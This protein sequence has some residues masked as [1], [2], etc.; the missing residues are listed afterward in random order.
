MS[1]R[2]LVS[3]I[4]V[5][6]NGEKVLK[7]CLGSLKKITYP[8]YEIILV[9]NGSTDGSLTVVESYK[10]DLPI[11]LLTNSKNLGFAPANNQG[12]KKAK[13]M[14]V[15]LL[16]NDTKVSAD[17][18]SIMVDKMEADPTIGALQPKIYMM[19]KPQYLDNAGTFLTRT[20]FLQHWGYGQKDSD[21]FAHERVI[22][23]AKG[24]CL[25]TRRSIIEK[26]GLFD[27]KFGSYFEE[28]DFCWRV[29]LSGWK[30]LYYPST[31]IFHKVGYTSKQMSQIDVNYHSLKNRI[32][33][34]AVNLSFTNIFS[35]LTFHI[36]LLT[37]LAIYYLIHGEAK[38]CMMIIKA[39]AWNISHSVGTMK[40]R[41]I[42]QTMR[43]ITDRELFSQVMVTTSI[44]EMRK[45]FIKV[46]KNFK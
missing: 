33:S 31:H 13:G 40:R 5:N 36:A 22:F 17:F 18:L 43:K 7:E 14:Y 4:I 46:E 2:P 45:H 8:H 39:G 16:N 3:I 34:L 6:W 28:S 12:V 15:L 44:S 38:K 32:R 37:G 1:K 25:L 26:V 11:T 10:R 24:A 20:G 19:D 30:V 21:E 42:V 27:E 41:A 9:D 29:W 35:M 23:S